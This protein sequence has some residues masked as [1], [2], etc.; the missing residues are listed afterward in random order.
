VSPAAPLTNSTRNRILGLQGT[1]KRKKILRHA[2]SK[3]VQIGRLA[4][5][6]A[7]HGP[8]SFIHLGATRFAR[9]AS[10]LCIQYGRAPFFGKV[11]NVKFLMQRYTVTCAIFRTRLPALVR[12]QNFKSSNQ[13]KFSVVSDFKR[14]FNKSRDFCKPQGRE[15]HTFIASK[16]FFRLSGWGTPNRRA[17][18]RIECTNPRP[19]PLKRAPKP[20]MGVGTDTSPD[21]GAPDELG[22][23]NTLLRKRK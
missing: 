19:K 23:D 20:S 5:Q 15:L 13:S 14:C 7:Q 3:S 1:E 16:T 2:G 22:S 10:F 18:G 8:G 21:L 17:P 11:P 6:L 9:N 4:H 12:P